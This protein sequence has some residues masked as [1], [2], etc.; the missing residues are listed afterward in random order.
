MG[1]VRF[2]KNRRR[3]MGKKNNRN[4]NVNFEDLREKKFEKFLLNF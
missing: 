1:L 3:K 4:I 2:Q